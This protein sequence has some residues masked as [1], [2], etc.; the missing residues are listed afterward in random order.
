MKEFM[1][2]FFGAAVLSMM[3]AASI[4]A[5]E[6][7]VPVDKDASLIRESLCCANPADTNYGSAKTADAAQYHHRSRAI[8]GFTLPLLDSDSSVKKA[9][10]VLPSLQIVGSSPAPLALGSTTVAWDEKTVTWNNQPALDLIA[11]YS[12]S[13]GIENRLDVTQAVLD[14]QKDGQSEISFVLDAAASSNVFIPSKEADPDHAAYLII[15]T[16]DKALDIDGPSQNKGE[17]SP[18]DSTSDELRAGR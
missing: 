3:S 5:A 7:R 14:T 11:G 18:V 2:G 16:D 10:L 6:V 13:T 1:K 17:D 9:E 12:V 15:T 4:Q 8:F